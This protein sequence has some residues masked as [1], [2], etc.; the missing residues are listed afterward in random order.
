MTPWGLMVMVHSLLV[1]NRT[2][3][4]RG[5]GQRTQNNDFG[6]KSFATLRPEVATG[7]HFISIHLTFIYSPRLLSRS[8]ITRDI[9]SCLS[10]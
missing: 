1:G 10:T 2:P 7:F 5:T 8:S 3:W 6:D 4:G 9:I